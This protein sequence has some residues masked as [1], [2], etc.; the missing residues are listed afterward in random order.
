MDNKENSVID[1]DE[2]F[3]EDA[4]D[5]F[6]ADPE[7][8]EDLFDSDLEDLFDIIRQFNEERAVKGKPQ[9]KLADALASK[10]VAFLKTLASLY[11][12]R[13]YSRMN[14]A[15]LVSAA[16]ALLTD[17]DE[18]AFILL[19]THDEEWRFFNKAAAAGVLQED[20]ALAGAYRELQDLG[21]IYPYLH[22]GHLFYVV[23]DELRA[24][25]TTLKKSKLSA[26]RDYCW[27]MNTYAA[28]AANLYG[29]I[30]AEDF[31][32]LFNSRNKRKTNVDKAFVILLR[33]SRLDL[34]YSFL[35][36]YI[37]SDDFE[38]ESLEDV[39]SFTQ[40]TELKPRYFPASADFLEYAKWGHR[41]STSQIAAL[42][43]YMVRELDLDDETADD[44]IDEL[45]AAYRSG[46]DGPDI[47]DIFYTIG[48]DL[49]SGQLQKLQNLTIEMNNNT[50][51][52]TNNGYTPAEMLRKLSAAPAA[53][54]RVG[55]NDPCP[56]GSGKKYKKCCYL[57][58][59][60]NPENPD[61][62]G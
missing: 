49:N 18:L 11:G 2:V 55:R 22:D 4:E 39:K 54:R 56:C 23:P 26:E 7:D 42:R 48:I 59:G 12:I 44:I 29:V 6:D 32:E 35:G 40:S 13:G 5:L 61:E 8:L 53:A 52:W 9:R 43:R 10:N 34:G 19:S 47:A 25:Y 16:A 20:S 41:E 33:C 38:A 50:R 58:E 3:N 14:K 21:L 46:A 51:K 1:I 27:L 24:V 62:K 37:V 17:P 31:V 45:Y 30:R 28:A 36:S 57:K 15:A 60:Q